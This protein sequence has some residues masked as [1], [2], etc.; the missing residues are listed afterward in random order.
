VASLR[1]SFVRAPASMWLDGLLAALTFAA[2][3]IALLYS[4]VFDGAVRSHFDVGVQ[5]AYPLGDLAF[6]VLVI[7][8]VAMSGWRPGARWLLIGCAMGAWFVADTMSLNAVAGGGS[9]PDGAADLFWCLG[10]ALLACAPWQPPIAPEG[11][12]LEGVRVLAVP[13]AVST[14][15]LG[16]C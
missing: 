9:I 12:R 10:L 5:T 1:R 14:V 2:G 6:V 15:A 3:G 7:A 13:A 11:L 4:S 16:G 8:V